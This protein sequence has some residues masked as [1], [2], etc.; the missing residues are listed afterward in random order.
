MST[1]FLPI[2]KPELLGLPGGR[3]T[4]G[5]R[6]KDDPEFP[7]VYPFGNKKYVVESDLED[8]KQKLLKRAFAE[9][10]VSNS[11]ADIEAN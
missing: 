7:T 3:R 11:A 4:I 10:S 9:G 6:M 2:S 8:Y 5:R 1:K